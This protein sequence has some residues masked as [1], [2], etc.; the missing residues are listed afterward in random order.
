MARCRRS[1]KP[2]LLLCALGGLAAPALAATATPHHAAPAAAARQARHAPAAAAAPGGWSPAGCG[3]EPQPPVVET[4]TIA[5][6]NASID[7]V[8]AYDAAART[9][10]AC[11]SRT[12]TAEQTAISDQARQRIDRIQQV[13]TGVQQR[14]AANFAALG[15]ALK[16]GPPRQ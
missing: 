8:T 11:V 7:A 6:Y 15:A 3:R 2:R 10:N 14:I 12:A 13:S 9:Y 1:W 16:K 5:R 4:T